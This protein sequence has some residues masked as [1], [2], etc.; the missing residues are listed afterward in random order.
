MTASSPFVSDGSRGE[1]LQETTLEFPDMAGE[2][3]RLRRDM[4][5]EELR[6]LF[7]FFPLTFGRSEMV[8]QVLHVAGFFFFLDGKVMLSR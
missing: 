5:G 2:A 3:F 6:L 1:S 8:P 4:A 7:P